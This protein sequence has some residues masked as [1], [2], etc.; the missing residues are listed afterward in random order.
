MAVFVNY[1]R[2]SNPNEDQLMSKRHV[3]AR[4]RSPRAPWI[5]TGVAATIMVAVLAGGPKKPKH[6]HPEPRRD[7]AS[8]GFTIVPSFFATSQDVYRMYQIAQ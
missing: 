8:M 6:I 2:S 5:I 4:P 3:L 1:P 7:A